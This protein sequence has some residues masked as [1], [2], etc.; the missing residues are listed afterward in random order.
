[1]PEYADIESPYQPKTALGGMLLAIRAKIIASSKPL[2]NWEEIEQEIKE[3][4]GQTE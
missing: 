1:M 2:L 4:R 3:R